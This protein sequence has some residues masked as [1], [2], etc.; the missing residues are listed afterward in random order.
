MLDVCEQAALVFPEAICVGWDVL[1]TPGFRR[2]YI[3]EGNAFGD[4]L[5][6]VFHE[7]QSAQVQTIR[8]VMHRR[9]GS[10]MNA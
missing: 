6:N 8:A 4:L 10:K 9:A 2:A 7:G 5:P 3:L 1:I